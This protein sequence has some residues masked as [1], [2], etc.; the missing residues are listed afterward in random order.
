M[1]L[2]APLVAALALSA[3]ATTDISLDARKGL[4][5][6]SA[7]YVTACGAVEQ[8]HA[9]GTLKGRDFNAAKKACIQADDLLDA[10]DLALAIGKT[11]DAAANVQA[12]FL[13]LEKVATATAEN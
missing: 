11:S 2:L 5:A 1:R 7:V 9:A 3:C 4:T 10:A 6:A 13:L 12:A 8:A